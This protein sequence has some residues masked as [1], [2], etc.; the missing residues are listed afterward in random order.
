M[1]NENKTTPT[2]ARQQTLA[3][4]AFNINNFHTYFKHIKSLL[5]EM[6]KGA[7]REGEKAGGEQRERANDK[8]V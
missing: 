7:R 4:E 8:Q 2:I 6:A 3:R 5:L 1:P